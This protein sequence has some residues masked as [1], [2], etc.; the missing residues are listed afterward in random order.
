MGRGHGVEGEG[1][2]VRIVKGRVEEGRREGET[3]EQVVEEMWK[4]EKER[5]IGTV[6]KGCAKMVVRVIARKGGARVKGAHGR[7]GLCKG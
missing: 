5:K 6:L 1:A 7:E 4:G 3:E 2:R